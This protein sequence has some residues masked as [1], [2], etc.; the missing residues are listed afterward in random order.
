MR[1]DQLDWLWRAPAEEWNVYGCAFKRVP[2]ERLWLGG[3]FTTIVA[4]PSDIRS[5]ASQPPALA[6]FL[7]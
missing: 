3:W 1:T 2:A 5:P 6:M 4:Q 7:F